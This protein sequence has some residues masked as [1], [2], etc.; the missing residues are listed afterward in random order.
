MLPSFLPFCPKLA[1]NR[2]DSTTT[3][4]RVGFT[5]CGCRGQNQASFVHEHLREAR[6]MSR[7]D[8]VLIHRGIHLSILFHQLPPE[9]LSFCKIENAIDKLM[10]RVSQAPLESPHLTMCCMLTR[11]LLKSHY[12]CTLEACCPY[13]KRGDVSSTRTTV[14][15]PR[16]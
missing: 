7:R 4:W 11:P 3:S 12:S 14:N 9:G 6:R 13:H 16:R 1:K 10:V 5:T 15:L 8:D 2:V